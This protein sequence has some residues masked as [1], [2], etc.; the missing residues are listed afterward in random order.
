MTML[1]VVWGGAAA[2]LPV[3]AIATTAAAVL[4]AVAR[5][6][7]DVVVVDMRM[8]GATHVLRRSPVPVLAL[9]ELEGVAAAV[10]AGARGC[11]APNADPTVLAGAAVSVAA[12][13]VIFG[14][15]VSGLLGELVGTGSCQAPDFSTKLNRV[16]MGAAT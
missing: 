8:P 5:H 14:P 10:R 15:G 12:G 1:T 9:T 11:V 13:E 16:R 4:A 2:G 6:E 3:A 7:P